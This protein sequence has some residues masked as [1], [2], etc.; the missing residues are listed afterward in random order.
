MELL[1]KKIKHL[2]AITFSKKNAQA[3]KREENRVGD[4]KKNKTLWH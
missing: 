3:E 2:E 1:F 4:Q